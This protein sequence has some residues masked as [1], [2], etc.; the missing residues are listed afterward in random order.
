MQFNRV[1]IIDDDEIDLFII[2]KMIKQCNFS[3]EIIAKNNCKEALNFLSKECK[4][5]MNLPDFIFCDLF[6]PL[7]NGHDFLEEFSKK[8]KVV[9][10]KCKVII[11]SVIINEEVIQKLLKNDYVYTF[12]QKPLTVKALN[13]LAQ[14]NS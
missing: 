7:Q 6:M 11:V 9:K 1:M 5:S 4:N 13:A 12:L 3:D 14:L 8:S 10:S 2:G